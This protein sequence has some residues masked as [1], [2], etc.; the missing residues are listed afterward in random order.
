MQRLL[1][2]LS[3]KRIV[4]ERKDRL[5]SFGFAY[6]DSFLKI[7]GRKIEV[8]NLAEKRIFCKILF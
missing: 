4:V 3:V 1:A 6:L 5:T 8:V 7:Q 2:D